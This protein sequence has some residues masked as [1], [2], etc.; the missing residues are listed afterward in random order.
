VL[1]ED[2]DKDSDVVAYCSPKA[3]TSSKSSRPYNSIW[4]QTDLDG[5]T[6]LDFV[7]GCSSSV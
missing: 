1:L 2:F 4:A 6:L 7:A 3:G 5:F